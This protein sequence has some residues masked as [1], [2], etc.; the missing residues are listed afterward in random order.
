MGDSVRFKGR[1]GWRDERRSGGLVRG[2]SIPTALPN[3][4]IGTSRYGKCLA[5]ERL[6]RQV[7]VCELIV[8]LNVQQ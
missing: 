7:T 4:S 5:S 1:M 8:S 2:E 3:Q 6:G